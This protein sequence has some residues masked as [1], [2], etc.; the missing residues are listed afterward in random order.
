MLHV[1]RSTLL[2]IALIGTATSVLAAQTNFAPTAQ[3]GDQQWPLKNV[4]TSNTTETATY[5]APND[6]TNN[7][8]AKLI[9]Q[10]ISL[11]IG[12]GIVPAA[13][14]QNEVIQLNKSKHAATIVL[15]DTRPLEA[16]A[17]LRIQ[18]EPGKQREDI[19][20]IIFNPEHTVTYIMHYGV[21]GEMNAGTR[22]FI[23]KALKN[24]NPPA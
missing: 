1:G 23:I 6:N 3:M 13:V 10:K 16:I 22:D 19:Q 4:T 8:T 11:N 2:L 7:P 14:A 12:K 21:N 20:R 9:I 5:L 17:D 15:I 18:L 24:I